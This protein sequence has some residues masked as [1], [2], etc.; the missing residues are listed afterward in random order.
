MI[1]PAGE[2]AIRTPAEEI[3]AAGCQSDDKDGDSGR[4]GTKAVMK[5]GGRCVRPM[6]KQQ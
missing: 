4:Q 2:V 6:P 3:E 1:Q 5:N